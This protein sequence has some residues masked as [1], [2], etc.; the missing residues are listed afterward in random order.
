M[1]ILLVEDEI[2]LS[3]IISKGL[4]KSG[5]AVDTAFDGKEAL[6]LFEINVYDLIILDLNLPKMDGMEV[7]WQIRDTCGDTKILILSARSEIHDK[8]TGLDKGANDYLVKPFDFQELEAR[9][10]NLLR[11]SF[12]QKNTI[13]SFSSLTLDSS[14]KTVFV[15]DLL[16]DLTKK[17]YAILEYLL[18]HQNKVISAEELIEHIWDSEVDLF[19]NSL[20]FHIHSLRKKIA[21]GLGDKEVIKTIRGQGY[22]I[23]ES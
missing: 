13:I 5:Y 2:T 17:E 3:N 14:K 9:I 23:S 18:F 1:K 6:E 8:I 20:K 4:K 16:I 19:S 7:L 10:R 11:R 21:V 12:T 22:M 15:N